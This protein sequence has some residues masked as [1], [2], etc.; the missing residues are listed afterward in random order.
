MQAKDQADAQLTAV[1]DAVINGSCGPDRLV[2]WRARL[3]KWVEFVR[4]RDTKENRSKKGKTPAAPDNPYVAAEHTRTSASRFHSSYLT[5]RIGMS[6]KDLM[7]NLLERTTM[8]PGLSSGL[9]S[10][11]D[12]GIELE[13]LK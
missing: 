7:E 9:I 3:R 1:E 11:I 10:A 2:E 12:E 5:Q 8:E 6:S 4:K 13:E